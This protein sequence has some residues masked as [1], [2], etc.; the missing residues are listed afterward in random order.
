MPKT[1]P[2]LMHFKLIWVCLGSTPPH[3]SPKHGL[4]QPQMTTFQEVFFRGSQKGSNVAGFWPNSG[5]PLTGGPPLAVADWASQFENQAL[6][7]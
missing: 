5:L 3:D 6:E 7:F 4:K 1:G 2:I